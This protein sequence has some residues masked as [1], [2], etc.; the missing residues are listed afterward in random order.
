MEMYEHWKVGSSLLGS[1]ATDMFSLRFND[2]D[3][4]EPRDHGV[5]VRRFDSTNI[6][7]FE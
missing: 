3:A 5:T 4:I 1:S 7:R 6:F 2:G